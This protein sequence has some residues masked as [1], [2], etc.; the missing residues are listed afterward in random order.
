M[1][2]LIQIADLV[3][4]IVEKHILVVEIQFLILIIHFGKIFIREFLKL[5]HFMI[6]NKII[7]F[8]FLSEEIIQIAFLEFIMA[9]SSLF[10]YKPLRL[11]PKFSFFTESISQ[12]FINHLTFSD[13]ELIFVTEPP[14]F[15][16]HRHQIDKT[17]LILSGCFFSILIILFNFM[18]IELLHLNVPSHSTFRVHFIFFHVFSVVDLHF[19]LNLIK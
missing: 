17:H 15:G 18:K 4:S 3:E 10:F 6:G 16:A 2:N 9:D 8:C 7:I 13:T 12:F 14:L 11:E 1:V 5:N 19:L